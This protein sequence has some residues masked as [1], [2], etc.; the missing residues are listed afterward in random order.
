MGRLVTRREA[1]EML[2]VGVSTLDG[3][4]RDGKLPV[5]RYTPRAVRLRVEDIE[6]FVAGRLGRRAS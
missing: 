2:R 5:V 4:I 3:Y 6:A 1:A